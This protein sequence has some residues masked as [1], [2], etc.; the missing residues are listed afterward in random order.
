LVAIPYFFFH[1][2][3]CFRNL[4]K[5]EQQGWKSAPLKTISQ[6]EYFQLVGLL[7]SAA[8]H[9]GIMHAMLKAAG[10]IMGYAA[11]AEDV[12]EMKAAWFKEKWDVDGL[13]KLL[14]ITVAGLATATNDDPVQDTP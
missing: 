5:N 8:Q 3:V 10:E 1:F 12:H 11:D 9:E 7:T 4:L 13:L 6:D 14:N 2:G